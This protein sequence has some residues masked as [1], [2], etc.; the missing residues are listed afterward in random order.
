VGVVVNEYRCVRPLGAEHVP[1]LVRNR[2]GEGFVLE[3]RL[4]VEVLRANED[5]KHPKWRVLGDAARRL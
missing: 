2:V 5:L 3:V 4:Q 1:P